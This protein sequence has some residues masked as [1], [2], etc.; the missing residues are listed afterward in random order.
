MATRLN[1]DDLSKSCQEIKWQ[2]YS[3]LWQHFLRNL[4]LY[5]KKKSAWDHLFSSLETC[6]KQIHDYWLII[7][8]SKKVKVQNCFNL[9]VSFQITEIFTHVFLVCLLMYIIWCIISKFAIWLPRTVL[10]WPGLKYLQNFLCTGHCFCLLSW[11]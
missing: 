10:N 7:R 2:M 4:S 8:K 6:E 1:S 3:S 5:S 9:N 11:C